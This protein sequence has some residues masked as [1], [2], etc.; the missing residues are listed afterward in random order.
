MGETSLARILQLSLTTRAARND[1]RSSYGVLWMFILTWVVG[2]LVVLGEAERVA[3]TRARRGWWL[4]SLGKY[5]AITLVTLFIGLSVYANILRP[6]TDVARTV[7]FYYG[8]LVVLGLLLAWSLGRN[9]PGAVRRTWRTASVWAYP[10]L[11]LLAGVVVWATNMSI[12]KADVYY[13]QGLKL[14]EDGR[15]DTSIRL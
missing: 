10:I 4:A 13:K 14:E 5:S 11:L 8:V 3:T 9:A 2:A 6:P 12:V 15:W 7:N 1:V